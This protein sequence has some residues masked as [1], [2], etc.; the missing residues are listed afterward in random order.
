MGQDPHVFW[1]WGGINDTTDEKPHAR[2]A[3]MLEGRLFPLPP[4]I[5][6]SDGLRAEPERLSGVQEQPGELLHDLT[7]A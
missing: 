1:E 5:C 7:G 4:S 6:R 3:A 2:H